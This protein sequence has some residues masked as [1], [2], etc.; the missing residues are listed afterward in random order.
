MNKRKIAVIG[1]CC[2]RDVFNDKIIPDWKEYFDVVITRYSAFLSI[3][4]APVP[5]QRVLKRYNNDKKFWHRLFYDECEKNLLAGLISTKPDIILV[6]FYSDV[7]KGIVEVGP[8]Q[9]LTNSIVD[10]WGDLL[11]A[12][13]FGR[14][15]KINVLSDYEEYIERWKKAVDGFVVFCKKYLPESKLILNPVPISNEILYPD[16]T[17]QKYC[18][19]S[20]FVGGVRQSEVTGE[21]RFLIYKDLFEKM[22]AYFMEKYKTKIIT[23]PKKK[24]YINPNHMWGPGVVHFHLDYY[25]D[26]FS[27]LSEIK[28][29]QRDDETVSCYN[30]LPNGD[31]RQGT[32]FWDSW[33]PAFSIGC[34]DN[35]YYV[36][37]KASGEKTNVFHQIWSSE[38]E[39]DGCGT[40]YTVSFETII[41]EF[42]GNLKTPILEIRTFDKNGLYTGKEAI[43]EF[44]VLPSHIGGDEYRTYVFSFYVKEKYFRVGCYSARS[45]HIRWRN[46]SVVRGKTKECVF[47]S[48]ITEQVLLEGNRLNDV[49]YQ[50]FI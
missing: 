45:G 22:Y 10:Q 37:L 5:V 39:A 41:Y 29:D 26:L 36:Q 23:Y 21:E 31:F 15:K 7:I 20:L 30:I 46:I 8:N 3:M 44:K 32:L 35:G 4:S 16:G 49:N 2:S 38:I 19:Q 47:E 6:D 18:L 43:N 40:W 50:G 33:D 9:Y 48:D 34:D 12:K 24:Y 13:S 27:E 11:A 25:K 17:I 28:T 1:A 42:D 14:I